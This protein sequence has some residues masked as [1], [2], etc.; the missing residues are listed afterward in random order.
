MAN[1]TRPES[2][3]LSVSLFKIQGAAGQTFSLL[4]LVSVLPFSL[5]R[6]TDL[7]RL[8]DAVAEKAI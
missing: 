4:E 1:I 8:L 2:K 5:L 6:G 3:L 7:L